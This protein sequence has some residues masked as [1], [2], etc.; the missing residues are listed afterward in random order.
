M[1]RRVRAG[2]RLLAF[3]GG[4]LYVADRL[5][6]VNAY[7]GLAWGSGS[8]GEETPNGKFATWRGRQNDIAVVHID[9]NEAMVDQLPF[10]QNG[11]TDYPT[12]ARHFDVSV[13]AF[14]RGYSGDV[15]SESWNAAATGAYDARWTQCLQNLRTR[16]HSRTGPN[17]KPPKVFIRFAHEWNA[18]FYAW[19]IAD[20]RVGTGGGV[21]PASTIADFKAGWARFRAL[22]RQHYPEAFIV[23]N[24]NREQVGVTEKWTLWLPDSD[25]YDIYGVDYYNNWPAIWTEEEWTASLTATGAWSSVKG[26]EGHR[27]LALSLGKPISFSEWGGK[28]NISDRA[29]PNPVD[30]ENPGDEPVFIQKMWEYFQTHAGTGAGQVLFEGYWNSL[31]DPVTGYPFHLL[32]DPASTTP[33]RFPMRMPRSAAKY[34]DLWSGAVGPQPLAAPTGLSTTAITATEFTSSCAAVT[35]AVEY[36]WL[37]RPSGFRQFIPVA[38]TAGTSYSHTGLTTATAYEWRV[39]AI[40]A[41]TTI[42][43]GSAAV[44]VTTA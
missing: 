8:A 2:T 24:T 11:Y 19:G 42:G 18:N 40:N 25:T 36:E 7:S 31:M 14:G 43:I 35:G 13:G 10:V 23:C 3:G 22:Q 9:G 29:H 30:P 26:I 20:D 44:A 21:R 4:N 37:R 6:D 12:W 5:S 39:L 27:Q 15:P 34:R 38:R 16:L 1:T 32:T 41:G 28:A 17:G 33:D